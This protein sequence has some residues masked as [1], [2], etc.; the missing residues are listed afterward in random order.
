MVG[1]TSYARLSTVLIGQR[2][3]Q[4]KLRSCVSGPS[5]TANVSK[6]FRWFFIDHCHTLVPLRVLTIFLRQLLMLKIQGM[7]WNGQPPPPLFSFTDLAFY[8]EVPATNSKDG[9]DMKLEVSLS[10]VHKIQRSLIYN[11]TQKFQVSSFAKL[12]RCH[13]EKSFYCCQTPERKE[14]LSVYHDGTLYL[15]TSCEVKRKYM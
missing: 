2:W 6:T 7:H 3:S 12:L 11:R 15:C 10:A 8:D 9:K 13:H 1:H 14:M 4:K 5:G